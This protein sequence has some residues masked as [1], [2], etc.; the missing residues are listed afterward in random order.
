MPRTP[1]IVICVRCNRERRHFAKEM[2]SSCYGYSKRKATIGL[3]KRCNREKQGV[4]ATGKGICEQCRFE[5]YKADKGREFLDKHAA[6]ERV[7][8]VKNGDVIRQKD[9]ERNII[10]RDQRIAYNRAYYQSHKNEY[11]EQHREWRKSNPGLRDLRKRRYTA[12]KAGLEAT[13]TPFQWQSIKD[14]FDHRCVYCN[15]KMDRLTQEHIISVM[16][17][18]AYTEYNIL[19]ACQS[20]NSRKHSATGFEFLNRIATELQSGIRI[21]GPKRNR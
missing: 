7:R 20:C 13:L 12:R 6:R 15:R 10:R 8:R 3:C 21:P 14:G 11:R 4:Y 18:G 16:H 19:P 9:R 5:E 17:G 1:R 2:C